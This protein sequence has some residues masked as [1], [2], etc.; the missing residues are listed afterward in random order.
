M[1]HIRREKM[2]KKNPFKDT[3]PIETEGLLVQ[4]L[5]SLLWI[6]CLPADQNRKQGFES[7]V[8]KP[9]SFWWYYKSQVYFKKEESTGLCS[10]QDNWDFIIL[11]E[12]ACE[13]CR[14]AKVC[15]IN[16]Q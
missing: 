1:V 12:A 15:G 5:V 7:F 2:E 4:L 11:Q 16:A 13:N 10:V 9:Q 3:N 14:E 8:R 6:C